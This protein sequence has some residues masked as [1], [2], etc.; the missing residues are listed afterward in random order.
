MGKLILMRSFILIEQNNDLTRRM[1]KLRFR[2]LLTI[3][4]IKLFE[5]SR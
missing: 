1:H 2:S 3:K 5:R 4:S